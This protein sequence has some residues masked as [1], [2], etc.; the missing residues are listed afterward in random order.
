MVT[1][2]ASKI[3]RAQA[4][5]DVYLYQ[6]END[7][8]IIAENGVIELAES[9]SSAAFISL[10]G[11]NIDGSAWWGDD[12]LTSETQTV[13]DQLPPSSGNLLR[14]EQ[15]VLSDLAW[16]KQSPYSW[17][18]SASAAIEAANRVNIAISINGTVYQY[19]TEW[20]K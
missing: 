16:M 18:I 1:A 4:M 6:T 3:Q 7:G 11:G 10:F 2:I 5:A 14:L 20:T 9:P 12:G 19:S 13:I 17:D 15:A 8:D